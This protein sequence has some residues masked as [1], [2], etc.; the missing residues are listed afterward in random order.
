MYETRK[1]FPRKCE[2]VNLSV[3]FRVC[4]YGGGGGGGGREG[5]GNAG[6]GA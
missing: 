1:T 5:G 2:Q 4:V 6:W 3:Q